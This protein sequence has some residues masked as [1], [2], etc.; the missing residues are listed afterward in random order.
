VPPP[1]TIGEVSG[2]GRVVV[3]GAGVM[4]A[5]TAW[6]LLRRGVGVV[7]VDAYGPG[8]ALASSGDESRVTRSAHGEDDHYP[9]WQRYSLA[10]W[11]EL[12]E[13]VGEHLFVPSGVLWFAHQPDGFEGR[14]KP[15]LEQLGIPV[16]RLDPAEVER[17]WPQA[18]AAEADWALFEPEGGALLARRGT[19]AVARAFTEDGGE[20]RTSALLAPDQTDGD[21]GR[22]THVRLR[23][24]DLLEADAFVFACGPWLAGLFPDLL[25]EMLTVT[26]Q[27]VIYFAPPPGDH[28]FDAGPLPTWVDYD[29]SFYGIGSVEGRG[30]KVAPDWPGPLVDPDREERRISDERVEAARA[31]MG[32][33]FPA[34]AGRPV[35]EGRVCQYELTADTHFILD[36]HPAWSNAWIVGGGSGH[37]FK[38]G[39][40]I[41]EYLA[42]L[43]ADDADAAAGLAPPDD[44]F[45]IRARQPGTA[46]R[47]A[48]APPP[49]A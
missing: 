11:Q 6:C 1:A 31:F 5:W 20:R 42:A 47:T 41:G 12:G 2:I 33:L 32:R 35:S 26:R 23:D 4:G 19:L 24:A 36:R 16:E 3:V 45:A 17:R 13:R 22:L 8:N 15:V 29:R 46:M 43:V 27:E 34:M 21:G 28:R 38:H 25:G 40:A 39:P 14:S 49:H 48:G 9:R 30:L 10:R 7:L 44:R 37:G 18:S